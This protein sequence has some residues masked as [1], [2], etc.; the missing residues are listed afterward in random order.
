M[1]KTFDVS[2]YTL[3]ELFPPPE[4]PGIFPEYHMSF[5]V[6]PMAWDDPGYAEAVRENLGRNIARA[7]GEAVASGLDETPKVVRVKLEWIEPPFDKLWENHIA[8]TTIVVHPSIPKIYVY[9]PI[10][11][12]HYFCSVCGGHTAMS[13]ERGDCVVCGTPRSGFGG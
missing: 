5:Q 2:H 9:G 13:N 12:G 4:Y 10:P 8:E 7:I 11:A 1:K 6:S 3:K